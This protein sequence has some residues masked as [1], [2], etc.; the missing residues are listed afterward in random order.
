MDDKDFILSAS[1]NVEDIHNILD[2]D[3]STRWGTK[4]P[5][6][7]GMFVEAGLGRVREISGVKLYFGRSGHD[8]P[9]G[10]DIFVSRPGADWVRVYSN[11]HVGGSIYWDGANPRIYMADDSIAMMFEPAAGDRIKLVQTGEHGHFD[12]SLAGLEILEKP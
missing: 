12:F 9:R 5:Q 2:G 6:R 3:K 10:L 11:P 1:H 8:Y 4:S 7:P